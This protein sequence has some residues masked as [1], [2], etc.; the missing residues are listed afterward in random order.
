MDYTT[1]GAVFQIKQDLLQHTALVAR[2]PST[3]LSAPIHKIWPLDKFSLPSSKLYNDAKMGNVY[4]VNS[5][6]ENSNL[7]EGSCKLTYTQTK[8][9]SDWLSC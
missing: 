1:D 2:S 3:L 8:V 5:G 6:R 4:R 9:I 7:L